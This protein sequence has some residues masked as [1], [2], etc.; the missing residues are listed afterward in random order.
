MQILHFSLAFLTITILTNQSRYVASLMKLT[1][2][3]LLTSSSITF[4]LSGAK[5]HFFCLTGLTFELM[6]SRWVITFEK[7][8]GISVAD[9][10]KISVSALSKFINCCHSELDNYDPIWTVFSGSSSFSR[11][12]TSC[13]VGWPLFWFSLCFNLLTDKESL[14]LLFWMETRKQ[15]WASCWPPCISPILFLIENQTNRWYVK[16]TAFRALSPDHPSMT[17]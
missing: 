4:C 7:I 6:L 16:T 1:A 14:G 3:S 10:I 11:I 9:Q 12:E 17:L 5:D 13:S 15:C 2:R 8:L